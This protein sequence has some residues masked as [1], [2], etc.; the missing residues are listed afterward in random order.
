MAELAALLLEDDGMKE[1]ANEELE[2][3]KAEMSRL[4]VSYLD[5]RF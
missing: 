5:M 4:Q 1:L 2:V 3:S